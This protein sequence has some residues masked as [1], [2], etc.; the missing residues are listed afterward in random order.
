MT[1]SIA[2]RITELCSRSLAWREFRPTGWISGCLSDRFG[3]LGL[4]GSRRC[5]SGRQCVT[6]WLLSGSPFLAKSDIPPLDSRRPKAVFRPKVVQEVD[7]ADKDAFQAFVQRP[8]GEAAKAEDGVIDA[9]LR[10]LQ[11]VE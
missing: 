4:F 5:D 3:I 2:W 8:E 10:V 1:R 9:T 7:V 6:N 11:G